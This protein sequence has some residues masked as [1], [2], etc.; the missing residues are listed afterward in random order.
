M[1][2]HTAVADHPLEFGI[3]LNPEAD[4]MDEL[5]R[6]AR[7]ADNRGLDLVGVMDHPFNPAAFDSWTLLTVL[8]AR[9]E[10]IRLFPDVA[11]VPLRPP[12]VLAKAAASLDRLSGGRI[13][14][15]LGAGAAVEA[16]GGMGGP[17]RTAGQ[18][19][20]AL[21]EG[22]EVIRRMW[23]D[24]GLPAKFDGE[25]YQLEGVVPGP[26][27]AH[28]IS[29][30]IGAYGRRMV[31]LTGRLGDGW[32]PSYPILDLAG[33]LEL[34]KVVNDAAVDAGREPPAVRRLYNIIG[35]ID[36]AG[37]EPFDENAAAWAERLVEFVLSAGVTGLMLT[38]MADHER[39]VEV[40]AAEVVPAVREA[41]AKEGAA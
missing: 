8:A 10:R 17:K 11:N 26:V 6:L 32:L 30:W 28:P 14:L 3:A 9:T 25:H 7:L 41:L 40:F 38:P 29:L 33:Y 31:E 5:I 27:P 39:Q 22:I 1:P 19:I 15:G 12:A 35:R 34:N 23:A 21:A 20:A 4:R 24:D 36:P 37:T 18:A 16:G 13:E 2:E